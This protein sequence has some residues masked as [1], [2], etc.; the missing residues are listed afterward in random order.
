MLLDL[1]SELRPRTYLVLLFRRPL[2]STRAEARTRSGPTTRTGCCTRRWRG[3]RRAATR[4]RRRRTRRS[5]PPSRHASRRWTPSS[6]QVTPRGLH[7]LLGPSTVYAYPEL[8]QGRQKMSSA[9]ARAGLVFSELLPFLWRDGAPAT[10]VSS[11]SCVSSALKDLIY[12][13]LCCTS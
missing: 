8:N 11:V 10:T 4:M 5:W 6:S 7:L 13:K 9:T 2:P 3:P 12:S 1:S